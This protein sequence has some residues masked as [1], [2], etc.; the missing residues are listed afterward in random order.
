MNPFYFILLFL[1]LFFLWA[2]IAYNNL[3]KFRTLV[4]ESWSGI[5]VQLKRRFDLIPNLVEIVKG[6]A[7]H[8]K[9]TLAKVI[10]LRNN[11][12][13]ISPL[14]INAQS[15]ANATLSQGIRGIFALA[16]NYPD[17]KANQNFME[18]Q[19]SMQAIEEDLQNSRR[20]YNATVRD[21]NTKCDT[22]PTVLIANLFQ[23]VRKPFFELGSAE[24]AQN[25]KI[26]F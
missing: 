11:A 21:Y 8:E 22:F 1:G 2:V 13:N 15:Q 6:Y 5:S 20:Y 25:V 24:E 18:L 12:I 19:H 7:A 9:D 23:F 4:G 17:L 14:D 3:V 16:E 26:S 10:E